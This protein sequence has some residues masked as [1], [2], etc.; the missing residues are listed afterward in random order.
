MTHDREE[1]ESKSTTPHLRYHRVTV[2]VWPPDDIESDDL[3]RKVFLFSL[4]KAV[5]RA[6][7]KTV[8]LLVSDATAY[9]T[10]RGSR[11]LLRPR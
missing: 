4:S 9:H 6:L 5:T 8:L 3:H 2:H 11:N 7:W 1:R 10:K